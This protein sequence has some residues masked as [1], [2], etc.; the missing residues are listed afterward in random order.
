MYTL[1]KQK[2]GF[3][4]RFSAT[5]D[6]IDSVCSDMRQFMSDNKLSD[7][8]FDAIL[9]TRE[10]LTNAVMHG[11]KMDSSKDVF[12]SIEADTK[13]LR[14]CV[15][16][17]GVGFDWKEAEKKTALPTDTHGRGFSILKQYFDSYRFNEIGNEVE[18]IKKIRKGA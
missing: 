14:I 17:S 5:F 10:V 9:G 2:N 4:I 6:G 7:L 15:A 18:L 8:F 13:Q 3:T 1:I 16:D 12:F 11:S